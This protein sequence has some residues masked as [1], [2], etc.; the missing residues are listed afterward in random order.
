MLMTTVAEASA[1]HRALLAKRDKK[2]QSK[3]LGS[4][5]QAAVEGGFVRKIAIMC[6]KY[7][8][9]I[10]PYGAWVKLVMKA[11]SYFF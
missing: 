5:I 3:S 4:E 2:S 11:E 6:S 1:S 7:R 8:T 10:Y 9:C